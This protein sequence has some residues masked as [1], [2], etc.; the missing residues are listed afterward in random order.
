MIDNDLVPLQLGCGVAGG[1]EIAGRMG[2]LHYDS[3]ESSLDVIN[4][5]NSLLRKFIYADIKRFALGLLSWFR[6]CYGGRSNLRTYLT[7]NWFAIE[8]KSATL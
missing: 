4:A 5:F 8:G 6:W 7:D 3:L 1:C 2:Q